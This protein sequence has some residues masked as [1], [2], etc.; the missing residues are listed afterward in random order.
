[1]L[2]RSLREAEQ[3]PS[4]Q[5][6]KA[7]K[8]IAKARRSLRKGF[9]EDPPM[10]ILQPEGDE[11]PIP[12][13]TEERYNQTREALAKLG[14]TFVCAIQPLSLRELQIEKGRDQLILEEMWPLNIY[15]S[16]P[17]RM[18]VAINPNDPSFHPYYG[19]NSFEKVAEMVKDQE[20]ILRRKLPDD[21]GDKISMT[22]PQEPSTLVQLAFAY[23]EQ[24]REMFFKDKQIVAF[25][26]NYNYSDPI[27][28]V[29]GVSDGSTSKIYVGECR[30]SRKDSIY[31]PFI[32]FQAIP[33]VV[34]PKIIRT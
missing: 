1:M 12:K 2:E 34:L 30:V 8:G 25:V 24:R 20:T 14:F 15:D 21:L 9:V 27:I 33:I 23:E 19:I 10:S 3:R 22:I 6:K 28:G 5:D 26:D 4:N 29:R 16:V 13:V 7:Q 11:I 18:E 17:R 32:N 31:D